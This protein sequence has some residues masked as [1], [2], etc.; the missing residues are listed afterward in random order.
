[1]SKGRLSSKCTSRV[2]VRAG[3]PLPRLA[4]RVLV[5]ACERERERVQ[6]CV[7]ACLRAFVRAC[8]HV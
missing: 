7:R 1:M 8:A 5:R 4:S 6:L 2:L 3:P